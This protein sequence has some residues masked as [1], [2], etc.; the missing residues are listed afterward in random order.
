MSGL[1]QDISLVVISK[2][3]FIKAMYIKNSVIY[4]I[5]MESEKM[6][7]CPRKRSSD[8]SDSAIPLAIRHLGVEQRNETLFSERTHLTRESS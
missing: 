7:R 5:D 2:P 3:R 4:I 8:S 6:R 1:A